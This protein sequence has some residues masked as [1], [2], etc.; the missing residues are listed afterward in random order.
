MGACHRTLIP[1]RITRPRSRI[2]DECARRHAERGEN[3]FRRELGI[4]GISVVLDK[5]HSKDVKL[6]ISTKSCRH[7]STYT[8]RRICGTHLVV[9]RILLAQLVGRAELAN[10]A[11]DAFCGVS[12]QVGEVVCRNP[13]DMP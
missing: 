9:I 13:R 12:G 6:A 8:L 10:A 2:G 4:R 3:A 5:V 11:N 1:R 7:S